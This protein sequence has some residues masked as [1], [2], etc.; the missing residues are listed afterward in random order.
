[1]K[2]K[3]VFT[4]LFVLLALIHLICLD[5]YP[6]PWF[7][8]TFFASLTHEMLSTGKLYPAVSPMLYFPLKDCYIYGPVYFSVLAFFQK[9]IGLGPLATRLPG[10]IS[11]FL[12]LWV[13]YRL[14]REIHPEKN[15][16]YALLFSFAVGVDFTFFE[17]LHLGRMEP[18]V[19][20]FVLLYTLYCYRIYKSGFDGKIWKSAFWA[21]GI[22]AL[23]AVACSPRPFLLLLPPALLIL[24]RATAQDV[25]PIVRSLVLPLTVVVA[26]FLSWIMA[27]FGSF[28]EMMLH[29]SIANQGDFSAPFQFSTS[30][31]VYQYPVFFAA[32][33]ATIIGGLMNKEIFKSNIIIGAWLGILL[34][35]AFIAIKRPYGVYVIPFAYLIV[36]HVYV[37]I[38]KPSSKFLVKLGSNTVLFSLVG[39]MVG[40][41]LWKGYY[42]LQSYEERN[43]KPV[44]YFI[45]H[46]V[47]AGSKM[48]GDEI[49]YYASMDCG[50][51]Y[52]Y[53]NIGNT[54]EQ[55]ERYHR[56]Q[57]HYDYLFVSDIMYKMY[58][59]AAD[60][61]IKMG[62][63]RKV[64]RLEIPQ[65]SIT[66]TMNKRRPGLVS[67]FH[68][69]GTLYKVTH[70]MHV[71][72]VEQ[73]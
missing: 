11:G 2:E 21:P 71:K 39:V 62:M 4:G 33:F 60:Y 22:F 53:F 63:L 30:I 28:S 55:R 45:A 27:S 67:Y 41:T 64:A 19:L 7:D 15:K 72:V 26:L 42:F 23:L 37:T 12:V 56:E 43:P 54:L 9:I 38:L 32:L 52:Q 20:L 29:Y 35:Y 69:S 65:S 70:P 40:L 16:R 51:D 25:L 57:Y 44:K 31:Y 66:A 5:R 34:F 1:M 50:V 17:S 61:Y 59:Y 48:V 18:L 47:P 73:P 14:F 46:H 58:G 10:F 36:F 68:Y 24:S 13:L 8:E 3:Y 49:Y 6:L